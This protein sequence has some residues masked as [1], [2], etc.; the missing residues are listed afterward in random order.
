MGVI[1]LINTNKLDGIINKNFTIIK[2]LLSNNFLNGKPFL[3]IGTFQDDPNIL[4]IIEFSAAYDFETRAVSG[5]TPIFAD[6]CDINGYKNMK[7]GLKW[8]IGVIM[9]NYK[10]FNNRIEFD[11]AISKNADSLN[12]YRR[13]RTAPPNTA[14]SKRRKIRDAMK[15]L[16]IEKDQCKSNGALVN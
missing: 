15:S 3:I 6:V 12:S 5:K 4:N 16:D 9:R 8:M 7:Q 11:K 10:A 1:Y 14:R 13:A 2:T